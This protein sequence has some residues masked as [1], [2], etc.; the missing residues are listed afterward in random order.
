MNTAKENAGARSVDYEL[1]H[2][3]KTYEKLPFHDIHLCIDG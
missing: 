1:L 2:I 3:C